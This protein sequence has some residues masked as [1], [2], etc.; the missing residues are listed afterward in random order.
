MKIALRSCH[1]LSLFLAALLASCNDELSGTYVGAGEDKLEFKDDKVYVSIWPAPT[2]EGA[3]ETDGDG[4]VLEV[5]GQKL[6]LTRD[7]DTITGGPFGQTFVKAGK[8]AKESSGPELAGTWEARDGGETMSLV[9]G[10]DHQVELNM[11][12]A[13][14]R[15]TTAGAYRVDGERVTIEVPGGMPLSLTRK[16]DAL[17]GTMFGLPV[18][19]T[20]S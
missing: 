20:K 10:D 3:Y 7:G 8:A 2:L 14:E 5:G 19:F 18:R 13:G 9:F 6:V 11:D 17:E 12:S 15:D 16:G 1:A 4:V